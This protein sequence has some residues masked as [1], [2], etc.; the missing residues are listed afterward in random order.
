VFVRYVISD[1]S[2]HPKKEISYMLTWYSISC[3]HCSLLL[4]HF[5]FLRGPPP[6]FWVHSILWII[7]HDS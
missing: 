1:P 3:C 4:L 7:S 6:H 2:H 5:I